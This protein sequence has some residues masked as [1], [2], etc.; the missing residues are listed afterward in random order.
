MKGI[1]I[2]YSDKSGINSDIFFSEGS[3][4][5]IHHKLM[6]YRVRRV[7]LI[8]TLYDYFMMEEDGRM[9]QLLNESYSRWNL[10]YVPELIRVNNV[11]EILEQ[12]GDRSFELVIMMLRAD[13]AGNHDD[14]VRLKNVF[15]AVPIVVLA[16]NRNDCAKFQSWDHTG[17]VDYLFIW[18]GDGGIIVSIIEF[19]EDS[20]NASTDTMLAG[21]QNLLLIEPSPEIYSV[22][23][24]VVLSELRDH[25]KRL[26]HGNL[27]FTQRLIR[28]K[29]RPRVHLA[30]DF[31][32]ALGIY[33]TFRDNLLGIIIGPGVHSCLID[34]DN[35]AADFIVKL[36]E[37]TPE[38]PLLMLG[39]AGQCQPGL[40]GYTGGSSLNH[41]ETI[42][43][44]MLRELGFGELLFRDRDGS[45]VE[46]VSNLSQLYYALEYLDPRIL[47]IHI[48]CGALTRWLRVRTNFELADKIDLLSP[49][50]FSSGDELNRVVM[51][52]IT[53]F[54]RNI[55]RGSIVRYSR[56]FFEDYSRFSQIDN[57]SIGGKARGLAFM[58]RMLSR[59]LD[60]DS[61]HGMRISIPRTLVIGTDVFDS[62][63]SQENLKDYAMH[64][65]SDAHLANTFIRANLPPR[66]L[67]DLNEFIRH[68]SQPLAVRSS[69]MLEDSLYQPFAG[70]YAT[71]MI[72]NDQIGV[73]LRFLNL[74]NAIKYVYSSTYTA[75]AKS[76]IQS[77]GNNIENE[78][79]AVAIQ[80]VVGR[81]HGSMFYPDFSGVARSFNYYPA[82][83]T[84]PSDGV[85]NLAVGLGKTI[86]DGG[87][88][89][90]FSP[91]C[92][93][94][95]P[96]FGS[97]D[98]MF[99][100]SQ[101]EFYAVAMN[102]L[103]SLSFA[104]EAQYLVKGD[105]I[106][107]EKDGVLDYIASTWSADN[108]A[109]YEG[110][111]I[112]GPRII[113]FAHILK[114]NVI[115]LVETIRF[116]IKLC[117]DSMG[118]PVEIE[119]AVNMGQGDPVKSEMYILQVRPM[120]APVFNPDLVIDENERGNALCYSTSVMGNGMIDGICDIVYVGKSGFDP[121]GS[122]AIAAEISAINRSLVNEKRPYL[123][124]GP[125]RWGTSDPWLGIPVQWEHV[126]GARVFV[127]T[128]FPGR[129]IEPSQGSHFFQNMTSLGIGY[130][131]CVHGKKSDLL[132]EDW[133]ASRQPFFE[134][135]HVRHIRLDSSIAIRIDGRTG[136]GIIEK[137]G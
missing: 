59:Y 95:L 55:Y 62:F 90:S 136:R 73:N 50:E 71:K 9:T 78:K 56:R 70:I 99:H 11:G 89:L 57:G 81:R 69:S 83:G 40:V 63:M 33:N 117:E 79:M 116:I 120:V 132:D 45:V 30:R 109:L 37:S 80:K 6:P 137:P 22:Y 3:L 96:Q 107:A 25:T 135:D 7:L 88:S 86:V 10:G 92:P 74:V 42:R 2:D 16:H 125:G 39:E 102:Q 20:I 126:S 52:M 94:V 68:E 131:S 41:A 19:I 91:S 104:D 103:S 66:I 128:G 113:T 18:Q 115:P 112:R 72:P 97:V 44:F 122:A 65:N 87:I 124:I 64:E 43:S 28:Q 121:A 47:A 110:I 118:T 12:Q 53:G 61:F 133:L 85:V 46:K 35:A 54:R 100:Y 17:P 105:I 27:T 4:F 13:Q 134:T 119:F 15:Q 38:L 5:A 23:L 114:N 58:D 8:A 36:R 21:L 93:G 77:S 106:T 51:D 24:P 129:I 123:L 14:M 127:E 31:G 101:R 26:L 49:S 29:A 111:N 32:Q 75:R 48:T 76:Y 130:F 67:G 108:E 60:D 82:G 84:A 34:A 1:Q 98:D